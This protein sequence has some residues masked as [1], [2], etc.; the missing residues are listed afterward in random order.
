[1]QKGL[2]WWSPAYNMEESFCFHFKHEKGIAQGPSMVSA[3]FR[4]DSLRA[5]KNWEE[6]EREGKTNQIS[7]GCGGKKV[8]IISEPLNTFPDFSTTFNKTDAVTK[9]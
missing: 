7:W 3:D 5:G 6:G 8:I 9:K 1:M 2:W 4:K